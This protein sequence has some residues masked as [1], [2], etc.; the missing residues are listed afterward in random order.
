MT[1]RALTYKL[2]TLRANPGLCHYP[3]IIGEL[4]HALDAH[5]FNYKMRILE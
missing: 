5:F 3:A 2:G 1:E 4:L